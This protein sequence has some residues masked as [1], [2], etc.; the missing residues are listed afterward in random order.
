MIDVSEYR[1]NLSYLIG[2]TPLNNNYRFFEDFYLMTWLV[3]VPVIK[4]SNRIAYGL[5]ISFSIAGSRVSLNS[6]YL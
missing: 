4:V 6:Y 1:G 5:R 2:L 3:E